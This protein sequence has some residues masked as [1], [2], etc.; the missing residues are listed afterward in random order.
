MI[1]GQE[2]S[3]IQWNIVLILYIYTSLYILFVMANTRNASRL[4]LT[5]PIFDREQLFLIQSKSY[6]LDKSTPPTELEPTTRW[7]H[8]ECYN[9]ELCVMNRDY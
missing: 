8:A 3:I 2:E 9:R 5:T 7:L 6:E 1:T 4:R